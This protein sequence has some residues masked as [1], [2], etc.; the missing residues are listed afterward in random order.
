L[1][2]KNFRRG[3]EGAAEGGCGGNSAA[4]EPRSPAAPPR[5][6]LGGTEQKNILFLFRRKNRARAKERKAEDI[7]LRGCRR[8]VSGG[9]RRGGSVRFPLEKGSR[10]GYNFTAR[11]KM[12]WVLHPFHFGFCV[13][14]IRRVVSKRKLLCVLK[15]PGSEGGAR[16]RGE[17]SESERRA[18]GEEES[19]P[20]VRQEN[21]PSRYP[22]LALQA[23]TETEKGA[24]YTKLSSADCWLESCTFTTEEE[25]ERGSD[26]KF[27][28]LG[29]TGFDVSSIGFGTWQLGGGR[30]QLVPE[31]Q[32]VKILQQ[33]RDLGVNIFDA[34]VVYGQYCEH[35][36]PRRR[37]LDLLGKAFR[38][39]RSE[40]YYCLKLG[41]FDEYTHRADFDPKRLVAQF[42]QSLVWL[43]TDYVDVCLIHAPSLAEVRD[44]KAITVLETL[45]SLGHVRAIGYSFEDEPEHVQAALAQRVDVIMLQYNLVDVGCTSVLQTVHEHGIGVLVGGPFKR[46]Y[47]TGRYRTVEDLP[48][49]DDYWQWNLLHN[50]DKVTQLLASVGTHLERYGSPEAL[51]K[52]ALLHALS[53]PAVGSLVV[54]HRSLEEIREN[55][56]AVS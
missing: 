19:H 8:S 9:G 30:W 28:R 1:A 49:E 39:R 36:V 7:F 15:H 11:G 46:G 14:G 22:R 29:R 21:S 12:E 47:L 37:S 5:N 48:K 54:G 31:E 2:A 4:P 24:R 42:Q 27:R 38:S 13:G 51:R 32:A 3:S 53:P 43:G 50:R 33:S 18:T 17:R 41:Q 10:K 6:F 16:Q 52:H 26:M 44:G 23:L 45:Q 55:I 25:S 56:G 40:V 34:A 20:L 35:A